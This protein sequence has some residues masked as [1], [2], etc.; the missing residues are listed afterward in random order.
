VHLFVLAS[1][2]PDTMKLSIRLS[3]ALVSL[4]ALSA[5]AACGRQTPMTDE[6]QHDL[7]QAST[8]SVELAPRA[9]ST[10]VVSAL[11]LGESAEPKVEAPK[12]TPAPRA[13]EH[14]KAAAPTQQRPVQHVAVATPTPRPQPEPVA[15]TPAPVAEA[16]AP[17]P[18]RVA[19]APAPAPG[20]SP[21]PSWEPTIDAN[22]PIS[23]Q[24]SA[25]A[26]SG[27]R[28]GDRHGRR[29]GTWSTGDV[30]RNAPFPVNP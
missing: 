12:T 25:R 4:S 29:G 22:A 1:L 20:M 16:P 27:D 24:G 6:L 13:P 7:D 28:H 23:E 5:L 11:E 17:A 30:I 18:A 15:Q 19:Q 21:S 9:K 8:S 3:A 10:A 26:T 14:A 2:T